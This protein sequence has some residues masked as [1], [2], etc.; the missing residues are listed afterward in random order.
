MLG[1]AIMYITRVNL[2]IAILDM[3]P[4][5]EQS[6]Q[7]IQYIPLTIATTVKSNEN[8]SNWPNDQIFI[9]NQS[10]HVII[11]SAT[12]TSHIPIPIIAAPEDKFDWT[13]PE[14]GIILGSFFYGWFAV[15]YLI[16]AINT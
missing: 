11:T 14:Q 12:L 6:P 2:N 5:T 3:V 1:T 9:V 7:L 4:S 13:Q 10:D 16:V 8:S 15:G